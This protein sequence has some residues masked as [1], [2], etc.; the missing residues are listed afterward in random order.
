MWWSRAQLAFHASVLIIAIAAGLW[1]LPL[2][3]SAFA[4][5][6]NWLSY[7][8]ALPQHCGLMEHTTDFRKSVRSMTLPRFVEFLYWHM[9][10]YTEHHMYAGVPRYNL[11]ALHEEVKEDMPE[12]R[13]LRGAWRE[14]LD[15][16][17]R[18]KVER[19]YQFDTPP[20]CDR[21]DGAKKK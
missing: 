15:V 19:T 11:R 3:F 6:G 16:W 13:T 14:M 12:P 7:F 21:E 9:N 2:S 17:E 10:W 4:F 1:V 20:T 5:I 18:Q 8:V